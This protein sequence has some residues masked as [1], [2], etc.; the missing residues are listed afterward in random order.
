MK[1]KIL[2]PIL[3]LLALISQAQTPAK[4]WFEEG[5]LRTAAIRHFARARYLDCIIN[6]QR[7]HAMG[8]ADGLVAGLMAMA[9]DSL[10]N[11]QASAASKDAAGK[12]KTDYSI[13]A[14]IAAADISPE[15]Y[16]RNLIQ[17]AA[18][19]YNAGRY[20]SSEAYFRVYLQLN[21]NDTFALFY[22]ANSLFNQERYDEANLNY[23]KLLELNFN[24]P[25]VHNLVG[26]CYLKQNNYLSARDYFSQAVLLDKTMAISYYNLGRVHYGLN[27]KV[28][29]IQSLQEAHQMMPR[30]SA[31]LALLGHLYMEQQDWK[32]AEKFMARLYSLNRGNLKVGW[33]LVD[34]ALKNK[35]NEHAA[36][37]LQN[38]LR[39]TPGSS[40]AYK[41][42]GEVYLAMNSYEQA[43]NNYENALQKAGES[44]DFLY[45]AG[46]CA[47]RIGLY[48]KAVEYL[49]KTLQYEAGHAQAHKELGD[50]YQGMGKKKQAK[51]CYKA[52]TA[53]GWKKEEP[54]HKEAKVAPEQARN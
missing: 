10:S 50:A 12:Y 30:D 39:V 1:T 47:N 41:K 29:A 34:L 35:D 19:M 4:I 9:Y 13:F 16:K 49:T 15:I 21:P 36:A 33:A 40:E 11:R 53:A 28:S 8:E 7:L 27:D 45:G 20:D 26:M 44:R 46:M 6:C 51:K 23:K 31:C 42:L 3:L 5:D 52:A 2:P 14:R 22:L 32:N 48:G 54:S 37:Y 18:R 24:R 43:F 38:I 17:T 25:D